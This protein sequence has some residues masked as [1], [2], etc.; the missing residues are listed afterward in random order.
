MSPAAAG[1]ERNR[2]RLSHGDAW[3]MR[4]FA[5]QLF[6]RS[7]RSPAEARRA[8]EEADRFRRKECEVGEIPRGGLGEASPR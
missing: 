1:E 4:G 5:P 6:C 8:K 7:S 3:W 2:G